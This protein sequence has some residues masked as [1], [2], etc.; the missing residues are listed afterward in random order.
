MK[1]YLDLTVDPPL[2][3][4]S[5]FALISLHCFLYGCNLFM[6]K[7][8]RINQNFI[9]DFVPNTALTHRDAFLMSAFIMCTV[10]TVL[11]INLF[12]IN[13]GVP[14]T[15]AVPG[16]LIVVSNTDHIFGAMIES[17]GCVATV[18]SQNSESTCFSC[19]PDFYSVRSTCS[20]A[21]RATA[22]CGSCAKSYSRHSTR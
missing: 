3:S 6:W 18:G 9:F 21:R 4:C 1:F 22:S 12:L 11:V 15:N 10:V 5:I 17:S 19:R 8:T 14:Y 2:F 20:T 7:S 13:A 16:A